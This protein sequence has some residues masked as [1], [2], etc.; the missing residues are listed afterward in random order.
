MRSGWVSNDGSCAALSPRQFRACCIALLFAIFIIDTATTLPI[1]TA[2]FVVIALT[3]WSHDRWMPLAVSAGSCALVF[4]ALAFTDKGLP[5]AWLM[6]LR[7]TGSVVMLGSGWFLTKHRQLVTA[8][9]QRELVLRTLFDSEP[10]CVKLLGRDNT[11]IEMNR[12]ALAMIEADELD[13]VKRHSLLPIITPPYREAF[14]R[15]TRDVFDGKSGSL[16]FEI[17]GRRGTRRWLETHGAPL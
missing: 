11:F 4:L 6:T 9:V 5:Q 13:V 10:A 3:F 7:A 14:A 12:G 15:L 2:Y 1:A 16:Q 17:V 8:S